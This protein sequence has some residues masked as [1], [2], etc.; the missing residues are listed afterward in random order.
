MGAVNKLT[1]LQL[2][3]LKSFKYEL[4]EAQM[5]E[6]KLLLSKYFADKA[7]DEMDNLWDANGWTDETMDDWANE[8]LRSD[9][10]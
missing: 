7:S 4:P 6:I 1:N 10:K 3:L 8:D 2:Q 5:I 9:G